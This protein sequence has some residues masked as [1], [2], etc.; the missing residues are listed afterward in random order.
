MKTIAT[1]LALA[2]PLQAAAQTPLAFSARIQNE[3]LAE[4][5][6]DLLHCLADRLEMPWE[7][8]EDTTAPFRLKLEEKGGRLIGAFHSP[9]DGRDLSLGLGES[10][11]I[12]NDLIEVEEA[13]MENPALPV[14]N[15]E[16]APPKKPW[17]WIGAAAAV[18]AGGFLLWRS[19]PDH[20]SFKME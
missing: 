1:I 16:P 20:R 12:C 14:E 18:L 4:E 6:I 13:A 8:N 19:Q 10:N 3:R 5:A 2:L 15:W 7:L 17:L 11:K 9:E